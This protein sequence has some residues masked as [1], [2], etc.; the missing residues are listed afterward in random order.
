MKRII[1]FITTYER[2]EMLLDLLKQLRNQSK[3]YNIKL[4]INN[5][6]SV[7]DYSKVISYL[8]R[9]FNDFYYVCD[10]I[11]RGKRNYWYIIN[12][13]YEMMPNESFDY[14][15]QV[16]DDV[17]LIE[18]FFDYAIRYFNAIADPEKAC[19]NILNDRSRNGYT[20]WVNVKPEKVKFESYNY[21]LTDCVDMAYICTRRYFELLDYRIDKVNK[22]W[23]GKPGRSSGV[24]MQ[25]SQRLYATRASIYQVANSLLIHGMH[26]SVMHPEHRKKIPLISNHMKDLVIATMATMPSRINALQEAVQSLI[27]QVDELHIYLNE[28]DSVPEF[29]K[30]NHKLHIYRSQE[31][32]GDLGDVGK[33]HISGN[34]KGYHFPVD[35]DIIYPN[36]YVVKM[37]DQ[38]EKHKRKYVIGL[39][40]RIFGKL[41]VKT[42]YHGHTEA[43]RALGEVK[44]DVFVHVTGMGTCC[45]HTDTFK[46]GLE[47]FET[48]NMTDVWFS[49]KANNCK[50]PILLIK[51]K[52]AW[53]KESKK[54]NVQQSIYVNCHR[55]DPVQ[56]KAVNE[57]KWNKLLE[58]N[59]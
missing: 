53:L 9:Y 17:K 31:C 34:I 35:D 59:F 51:H 29:L 38:A 4:I 7:S 6:H 13:I 45:Y 43:F 55:D 28:F 25:I 15:I 39:H 58:V 46:I 21:I 47:D 19:L 52:N 49:V 5:D 27:P 22:N 40:G 2:P 20:F 42:Y 16:P 54:Y 26:E 8:K 32:A 36:D 48:T 44:E 10:N 56:T 57:T 33:F 12:K 11:H 1:V 41:P 23:S 3:S 50:I 37:I 18:N 24:G 14:F 30:K